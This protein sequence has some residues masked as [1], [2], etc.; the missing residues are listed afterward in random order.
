MRLAGAK[1]KVGYIPLGRKKKK[2]TK[3]WRDQP[4]SSDRSQTKLKGRA[5]KR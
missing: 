3:V 4:P 1:S 2:K 5:A